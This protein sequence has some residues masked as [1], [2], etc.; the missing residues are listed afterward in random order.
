MGSKPRREVI[1]KNIYKIIQKLEIYG[2]LRHGNKENPLDEAIYIIL[3]KQTDGQRFSDAYKGLKRKC[4]SWENL[5][6]M[7]RESIANV[8]KSSGLENQKARQIKNLVKKIYKDKGIVSLAWLKNL[9][10][11]AALNYLV[12]LPGLG[13][14]SAYCILMYSLGR[15]VL[16]VDINVFR[17]SY[18]LGLIS[19]NISLIEAHLQL[20]RLI[21]PE[22][23]YSYHVNCISLGRDCCRNRFPK[24]QRC[25]LKKFCNYAKRSLN[26][27]SR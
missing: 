25:V 24:C 21:P 13:I 11:P 16:P 1:I 8:I 26:N 23:R 9:E 15:D 14:K 18:R 5:L 27:V 20:E 7:P 19:K 3:S 4:R 2:T 12:G 10:T 6:K 17:I 22:K